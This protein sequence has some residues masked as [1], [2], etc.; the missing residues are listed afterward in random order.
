MT[1]E[2]FFEEDDR[3]AW[4]TNAPTSCRPAISS[5][6]GRPAGVGPDH[7]VQG[8]LRELPVAAECLDYA[9]GTGQ[10]TGGAWGG[11][12]EDERQR[13]AVDRAELEALLHE[14]GLVGDAPSLD[15][16]VL[17]L[18][19]LAA[20]TPSRLVGIALGDAIADPRQ[21]NLPGTIDEYPN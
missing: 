16:L 6:P 1:A 14:E 12:P 8:D 5:R 10:T 17:A 9:L 4:H 2:F 13:A 3:S 19:E 7:S 18:Q 20:R 11:M 15:D 21:P